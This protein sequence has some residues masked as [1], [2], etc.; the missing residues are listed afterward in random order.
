MT[1]CYMQCVKNSVEE[2]EAVFHS[3]F[4]G[5][6][7]SQ[8]SDSLVIVE[9]HG[10]DT[11]LIKQCHIS[12]FVKSRRDN[13]IRPITQCCERICYSPLVD[14]LFFLFDGVFSVVGFFLELF[15]AIIWTVLRISGTGKL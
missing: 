2:I 3:G 6:G 7:I 8:L 10:F 12:W 5:S 11:L 4:Q 14:V 1:G 15:S 9:L 13:R